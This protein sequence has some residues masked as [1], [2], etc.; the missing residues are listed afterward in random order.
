MAGILVADWHDIRF[1]FQGLIADFIRIIGIT[2]DGRLAAFCYSKAR[3]SKPSIS[4]QPP[5]S[6]LI[7]HY[8]TCTKFNRVRILP[9]C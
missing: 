8:L 1:Q 5:L 4:I 9:D 2:N 3:V 6:R 7:I